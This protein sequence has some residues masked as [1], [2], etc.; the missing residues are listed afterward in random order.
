MPAAPVLM[1]NMLQFGGHSGYRL[2][3]VL[4]MQQ[5]SILY[6]VFCRGTFLQKLN[7]RH[8][9]G[10]L[11]FMAFKFMSYFP[12]HWNIDAIVLL[13]KPPTLCLSVF[14]GGDRK[15]KFVFRISPIGSAKSRSKQQASAASGLVV[16]SLGHVYVFVVSP[17]FPKSWEK[18]EVRGEPPNAACSILYSRE[19]LSTQKILEAA[20]AKNWESRIKR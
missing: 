4:Q 18:M 19:L 20:S 1:H 9:K 12:P 10:L 11:A 6:W 17:L 13:E 7:W 14:R 2:Q 15:P 16:R 8:V 5:M 3:F